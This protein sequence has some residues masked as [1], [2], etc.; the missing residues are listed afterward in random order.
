MSGQIVNEFLAVEQKA[1]SLSP[2]EKLTAQILISCRDFL[3]A[4]SGSNGFMNWSV[5]EILYRICERDKRAAKL[6][7]EQ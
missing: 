3:R 5:D 4:E 6:E 2:D 1:K 7:S